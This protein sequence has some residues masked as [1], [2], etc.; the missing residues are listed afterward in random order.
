MLGILAGGNWD[1]GFLEGVVRQLV[2][3]EFGSLCLVCFLVFVALV[4]V[5]ELQ[6]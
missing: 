2:R 3:R 5:H 6:R 1:N 4:D